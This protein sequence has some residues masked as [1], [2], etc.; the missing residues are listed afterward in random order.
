MV[1][2]SKVTDTK[3]SSS[4]TKGIVPSDSANSDRETNLHHIPEKSPSTFEI[5]P[6]CTLRYHHQRKSSLPA[7]LVELTTAERGPNPSMS[8]R[9]Y[10][11]SQSLH[12]GSLREQEHV[13][14]NT[15]AGHS[16]QV[17]SPG[18]S[19][20]RSGSSPQRHRLS[21]IGHVRPGECKKKP[22]KKKTSDGFGEWI[23]Y[24]PSK[25]IA[26]PPFHCHFPPLLHPASSSNSPNRLPRST[27]WLQ[28]SLPSSSPQDGS[29]C[30]TDSLLWTLKK[31]AQKTAL[32]VA[33]FPCWKS[34]IS[35][36]VNSLLIMSQV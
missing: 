26:S 11:G 21:T 8:I 23:S 9:S 36:C 14:E 25:I 17:C 20:G 24:P 27:G 13:S 19:P 15:L 32:T 5:L 2:S 34:S 10:S 3:D 18:H 28:Q 35:L 1:A 30:L 6:H 7:R 29:S 16:N 33:Q 12:R 31:E 4:P 22:V